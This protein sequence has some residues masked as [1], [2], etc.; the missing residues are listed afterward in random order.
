[1]RY[2]HSE[3]APASSTSAF[4]Y[5]AS[6]GSGLGGVGVSDRK[7]SE[8]FRMNSQ[9]L[10]D[11][12]LLTRELQSL[13]AEM[14]QLDAPASVETNVLE[15]FRA[16]KVVPI[17]VKR[18]NL[19]YWLAAIAAV[20]LIAITV[21]ALRWQ[22]SGETP[23]ALAGKESPNK[24]K[25]EPNNLTPNPPPKGNEYQAVNHSPKQLEGKPVRPQ[26]VRRSGNASMANHAREIATDFIPL[27]YMNAASLQDGGQVVRVEL[28][29]SAL[30]NFGLP[31]NM[32]RYNEKVK[33]DV[34]FGVD[35]LAHAIRFVQ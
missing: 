22:S 30:A 26:R 4:A 20:L 7:V 19:R 15:A 11:E 10:S 29:R 17:T 35:G 2:R 16:R 6:T 31:V 28:P 34:I 9:R 32:D 12:E 21:V 24:P 1:L 18:S 8:V 14:N 23:P 13:A 25:D 3:I 5:K 27:R 33:A